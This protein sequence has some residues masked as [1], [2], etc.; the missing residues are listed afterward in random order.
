[1]K[2]LF[3]I[4]LTTIVSALSAQSVMDST[5]SYSYDKAVL[6]EVFSD[7]N[8]KGIKVYYPD[9]SLNSVPVTFAAKD[10][11]VDSLLKSVL[12]FG[13]KWKLW[14]GAIIIARSF[15]IT[16][17][18]PDF[19]ISQPPVNNTQKK[20]SEFLNILQVNFDSKIS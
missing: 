1:M 7:L 19:D 13:Y 4:L 8:A 18:L 6:K 11:K 2:T 16:Q 10:V 17:Q 20:K 5:W 15:Y 14:N 9:T 12:P 3:I